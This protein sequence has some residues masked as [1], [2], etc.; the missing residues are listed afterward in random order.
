MNKQDLKKFSELMNGM[1]MNFGGNL[2]SF[3]IDLYF[4]SLQKYSISQFKQAVIWLLQNRKESFI[5]KIAEIIEV[6]NGE[7]EKPDLNSEAQIQSEIALTALKKWGG[8][9]IETEFKHP[10]TRYIMLEKWNYKKK[11]DTILIE[12]FVWFKKEF[13]DLF[14]AVNKDNKLVNKIENYVPNKQVKQLADCIGKEIE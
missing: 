9:R 2:N 1:A 12:D 6:I 3:Q 11:A 5:P 4:E 13:I 8:S 7:H 14:I 10:V